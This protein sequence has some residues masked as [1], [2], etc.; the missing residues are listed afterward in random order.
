MPVARYRKKPVEIEAFHWD[1]SD[2]CALDIVEWAGGAV[3]RRGR[4]A[5][6]NEWLKVS[7]LEG[8]MAATPGDFIIKGI[9]GE[10]YP[11]KPDIFAGSYE[12]VAVDELIPTKLWPNTPAGI[13]ESHR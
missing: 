2:A 9:A 4:N 12:P 11:C 1:G 6:G 10:F 3:K 7:T 8:E 5:E 13:A